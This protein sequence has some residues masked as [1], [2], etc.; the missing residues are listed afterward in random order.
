LRTLLLDPEFHERFTLASNILVIDALT[1]HHEPSV[2]DFYRS[3]IFLADF[4]VLTKTDLL[5]EHDAQEIE[6]TIANISKGK[7][8]VLGDRGVL[9]ESL[10]L[11]DA[12][13]GAGDALVAISD[14]DT[15][16]RH[17]GIMWRAVAIPQVAPSEFVESLNVAK[18]NGAQILR[19]KG[20]LR[21]KEGQAWRVDGTEHSSEFHRIENSGADSV[22]VF[23]GRN[24][25]DELSV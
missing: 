5:A 18:A 16:T 3:D 4:V 20:V 21:D 10:S 6:K 22:V 8:I 2:I 15:N 1:L 19:I 7:R 13:S 23:I 14:I 11:A 24:I 25:P 12:H 17:E 9:P